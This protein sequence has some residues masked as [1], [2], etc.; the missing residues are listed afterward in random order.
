MRVS[1]EELLERYG[2]TYATEAGITLRDKPAAL[3]QLLVLAQLSSRPIAASVAAASTH[4]LLRAGWRTPE[5]MRDSTWQE[6]VDALGRGGYRRY[7]ESTARDLDTLAGQLQTEH[8]GDLR[9]LRPDD[10]D[11][12]PALES[13]LQGFQRIG[14]TGA[15][16]FCREVQAVWPA[17]RP[18]FDDKARSAAGDI[19][20]PT[21]ADDLAGLVE[22]DQVAAFSSALVRWSLE[23]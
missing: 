17:V 21:D 10:R 15:A 3:F 1:P 7:D 20:Y 8:R 16:I 11:G 9:R 12:V 18:Y 14:P 4:E 2:T 5:R 23:R 19:G 22:P 13:A 6:R